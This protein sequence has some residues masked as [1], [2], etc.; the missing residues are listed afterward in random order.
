MLFIAGVAAIPKMCWTLLQFTER[1]NA[2]PEEHGN[3][4]IR[5]IIPWEFRNSVGRLPNPC[6]FDVETERKQEG[7]Q[8]SEN[9]C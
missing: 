6:F 7:F 8:V 9:I 5:A 4:I 1:F 3:H 2:C